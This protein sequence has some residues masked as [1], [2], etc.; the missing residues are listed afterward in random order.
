[1]GNRL[2]V[3]RYVIEYRGDMHAEMTFITSNLRMGGEILKERYGDRVSSRLQEMCNYLVIKGKDRRKTQKGTPVTDSV[4]VAQVFGKMHK[5]IMK[6]I[7]NIMGSAQ[8]L[9]NEHW[10]AE[11]TYTDAQGK[12]QPMFLMNRDGFSL[13]TMSLTGEKAMAF[14]VAFINAFNKMEET[15]KGLAPASPAIPQTFAQALR[16]AAEQA[17]TIESQ[18]KQIEAQ[19]PKVAFATA[20]INSPSSCGIDELA[21]ILKQNGVDFGEIRLFQWLRDNEYLCSVGT[22][23]NQPTQ[24]ALDLGL[25]ELKPQTWTNPR[26]D[27]VMTTTRTMV[28]GKG[29]EYFINKFIY[30]AERKKSQ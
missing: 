30:N 28:T 2:D 14:K 4:K 10:F 27:E 18:Q 1:M 19:A 22:A 12:R 23:R 17:E 29:K 8:N 16:L 11:T 15:I 20:I 7:R 24:K 26:T 13:L 6:S 9:A 5:N 3:V 21:K 25:F